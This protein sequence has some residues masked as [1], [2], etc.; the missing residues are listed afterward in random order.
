MAAAA[1]KWL[2]LHPLA[3]AGPLCHEAAQMSNLLEGWTKAMRLLPLG[4][5]LLG[6][7]SRRDSCM[8]PT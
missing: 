8:I 6:Q 7:G 5:G 4:V 1:K 3:E 2:L